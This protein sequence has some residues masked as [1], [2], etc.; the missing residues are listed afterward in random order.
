LG[1]EGRKVTGD[2][3]D[4]AIFIEHDVTDQ[5][6][7]ASVIQSAEETFGTVDVLVNNAAISAAS[8]IEALTLDSYHRTISV[9]QTSVL[10]GMKARCWRRCG[11]P[12]EDQ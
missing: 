2:L 3:G 5:R 1:D 6:A 11:E 9:N 12:A 8:S 7:W 10:L 4:R